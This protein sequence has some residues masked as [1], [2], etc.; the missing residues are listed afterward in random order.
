MKKALITLLAILLTLPVSVVVRADDKWDDRFEVQITSSARVVMWQRGVGKTWYG[1]VT[2]GGQALV[3]NKRIQRLT[4]Q[5]V[6]LA[7]QQQFGRCP[8]DDQIYKVIKGWDEFIIWAEKEGRHEE[9][10]EI[11]NTFTIGGPAPG[12]QVLTAILNAVSNGATGVFGPWFFAKNLKPN[13]TNVKQNVHG[14]SSAGVCST[15][16]NNNT[17]TLGTTI[18]VN[19][20]NTI[21]PVTSGAAATVN[22]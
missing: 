17:N 3:Q 1:S 10:V 6:R 19:T 22:K 4:P 2:Q 18:G 5:Q 13:Q 21:G 7:W 11:L 15:D 8:Q 12:P 20:T 9:T 16:Y 14:V